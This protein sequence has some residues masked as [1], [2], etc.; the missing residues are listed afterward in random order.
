MKFFRPKSILRLILIGFALVALPLIIALVVATVAVDRL[1]TE[2]Q[3]ALF[4]SVQVTQDTQ[5]LLESLTAMERNVR[6]YQVLGDTLLLNVYKENR[7]RFVDTASSLKALDLAG[8]QRNLLQQLFTAEREVHVVLDSLPHDDPDA[9]AAVQKYTG[10]V[11]TANQ[12]L[13]DNQALINRGLEQMQS[14]AQELQHTLIMEAVALIPIAILLMVIFTVL[15]TRPINQID[16]AIRRLGD[17]TLRYPVVITGPRD[18]E[19]LGERLNWLQD[20]MQELEQEKTKFLQHISHELKTPLTTIREGAE[21]MGEQIV[22]SLNS[23]QREIAHILHENSIQLQKLIEDLLDFSILQSH[24]SRTLRARVELDAVIRD[25]L[26]DHKVAILS[27]Q[28]ELSKSLESVSMVGDRVKLRT[29]VD[30]LV[31]NA[32]KY[33]PVGSRLSVSLST[34]DSQAFIEVADSGPGI[35]MAERERVFEAFFQGKPAD[36][37]HIRG[38]GLGLSIAREHA[39]AHGGD[40]SVVECAGV[41]ACLRVVLPLEQV[42]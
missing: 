35:P 10:L 13:D 20:R 24:K 34:R 22:G 7:A 41:G 6:Q 17:G 8:N 18:L 3:H 9:I 38:S 15:I 21:L 1:V 25:V 40:I 16:R 27:R 4:Q 32:I 23:Q 12:I 19:Q 26:D 29:L 42:T 2:S 37:G 11:E 5:I 28:L 39:Q 14:G 33:S 31:S 30:N 36:R